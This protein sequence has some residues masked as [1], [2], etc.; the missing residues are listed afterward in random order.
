MPKAVSPKWWRTDF[1]VAGQSGL[2]GGIS[3]KE[4]LFQPAPASVLVIAVS[5]RP[6][7]R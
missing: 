4:A 5:L 1:H 3:W 6:A 2:T 7:G